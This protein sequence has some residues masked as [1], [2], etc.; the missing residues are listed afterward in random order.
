MEDSDPKGARPR[1]ESATHWQIG[2]LR[3]PSYMLYVGA[4]DGIFG[5]FGVCVWT[6]YMFYMLLMSLRN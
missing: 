2:P 6:E 4:G 1:P 3:N 5:V